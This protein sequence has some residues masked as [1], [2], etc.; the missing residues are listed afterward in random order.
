MQNRDFKTI[1]AVIDRLHTEG[2]NLKQF[3]WD[4]VECTKNAYL[5]KTNGIE[6]NSDILSISEYKTLQ[7]VATKWDLNQLQMTFE[8]LYQLYSNFTIF[9]NSKS[10]EIRISIE[11]AIMKIFLKL[12]NPSVST[13]IHKLSELKGAIEGS[14]TNENK[15]VKQQIQNPIKAQENIPKQNI[16]K[17]AINNIPPILKQQIKTNIPVNNLPKEQINP[18]KNKDDNTNIVKE[19]ETIF[20]H[21]NEIKIEH[22]LNNVQQEQSNIVK[23]K[24]NSNPIIEKEQ[25][26]AIPKEN[27]QNN[28]AFDNV[29]KESILSTKNVNKIDTELLIEKTFMSS[30]VKDNNKE[31]TD[32]FS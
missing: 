27:N 1:L 20:S 5:I 18:T 12:N 17:L 25:S 2:V 14:Y 19:K 21:K 10:S 6:E 3:I 7:A 26:T 8:E 13:L 23:N 11:M 4:L 29:Q 32:L 28:R 16:E 9:Q 31:I 15:N 24:D 30:E 22:S